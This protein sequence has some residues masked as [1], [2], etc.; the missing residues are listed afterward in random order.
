MA[1]RRQGVTVGPICD[2]SGLVDHPYIR[3]RGV[4]QDY[5]Y[6]STVRL[7]MNQ[8]FP[9]LSTT[10]GAV[11]A[12]APRLGHHTVEIQAELG[13]GDP[14]TARAADAVVLDFEASVIE[15]VSAIDLPPTLRWPWSRAQPPLRST[16]R[17]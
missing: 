15:G 5:E 8:T 2:I 12:S 4:L 16:D 3:G 10:P 7:P 11:R 1:T 6:D 17:T 14:G 9:R 13:F